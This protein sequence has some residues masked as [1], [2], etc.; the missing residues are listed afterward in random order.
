[1]MCQVDY[2]LQDIMYLVTEM[3]QVG[4]DVQDI[5]YLVTVRVRCARQTMITGYY[6]PDDCKM[7]QVDYGVQDIM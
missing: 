6:V 3:C 1:M 5:M 4:Y 2:D 7:C